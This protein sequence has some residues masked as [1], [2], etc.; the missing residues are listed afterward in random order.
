MNVKQVGCREFVEYNSLSEFYDYIINTPLNETFK[1]NNRLSSIHNDYNFTQTYSFDEAI[2]LFK[3]GWQDMSEK[4]NQML[5]VE[6]GKMEKVMI[7]KNTI[8]VQGYQP[9]VPLY[10]N[11]IPAN[12]ISR[13]MQP[14][15]QKVITLNKSVTYGSDT[16]RAVIIAESIK[17]LAIIKKLEKQNYR[18]NLNIILGTETSDKGYTIKVRIKSANERLNINKLSFP[19]V[20]PSMLR[21]LFFR[22]IE[23]YPGV[24]SSFRVGYGRPTDAEDLQRAYPDEILLPQFIRKDIKSINTLKD[25][26][27]LDKS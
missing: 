4:L 1:W 20:H 6:M 19:L 24:P 22:F 12:M 18:C 8:S 25:L 21:R 27:K 7:S 16:P 10:L 2:D 5:K 14:M 11:G 23:T 17:A 13:K 3:T 9:I 15:K 26:E